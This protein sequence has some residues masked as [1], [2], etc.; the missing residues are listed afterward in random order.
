MEAAQAPAQPKQFS[1][2]WIVSAWATLSTIGLLLC[3]IFTILSFSP[4][5]WFVGI[6]T[7]C[8]AIVTAVMEAPL[9]WRLTPLTQKLNGMTANL[10]YWHKGLMYFI[11]VLPV[12]ACL[13]VSTFFAIV[14]I[15]SNGVGFFVLAIGPKGSHSHLRQQAAAGGDE[16]RAG[17]IDNAA[18]LGRASFTNPAT[19][20]RV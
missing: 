9:I 19:P 8:V 17:L 1:N 13:G 11:M 3:G 2:P 18:E 6:Y 14:L 10:K 16:Q 5:C 7:I 20:G 4:T 12:F 15:L